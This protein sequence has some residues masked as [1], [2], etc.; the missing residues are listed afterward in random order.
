MTDTATATTNW[1][2]ADI[3]E[4]MAASGPERP[5]RIGGDPVGPWDDLERRAAARDGAVVAA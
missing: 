4:A 1:N 5:G 2:F 3:Y